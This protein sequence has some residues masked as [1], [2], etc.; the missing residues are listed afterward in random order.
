M[1]CIA[2]L[3]RKQRD[4]Q[5]CDGCRACQPGR[6]C[7]DPS[8]HQ[9]SGKI[10]RPSKAKEAAKEAK[11]K[12]VIL[13][14]PAS[15]RPVR[16]CAPLAWELNQSSSDESLPKSSSDESLP[17][18]DDN[19]TSSVL[20]EEASSVLRALLV[21]N[22]QPRL[23]PEATETRRLAEIALRE[24]DTSPAKSKLLKILI[25][26]GLDFVDLAKNFPVT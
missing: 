2:H 18:G 4:C 13:T 24:S 7:E 26:L 11:K 17:I 21:G 12:P 9:C 5:S 25:L 14:E 19:S 10:G 6:R 20:R 15:N 8:Y 1:P 23:T 22:P 16:K 3:K